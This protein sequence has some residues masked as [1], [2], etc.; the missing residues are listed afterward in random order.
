M[1]VSVKP[2]KKKLFQVAKE[3]NLSTETI[4]EFL[5]KK[6]IAVR[7]HNMRLTEDVYQMVLERFSYEK[8]VAEKIEKRRKER[9]Q[10]EAPAKEAEPVAET[11]PEA[12]VAAPS[13]VE[14]SEEE[15]ETKEEVEHPEEVA[16]E[17]E[18]E[19]AEKVE[20]APEA[21]IE[22]SS[23]VSE[24]GEVATEAIGEE[25]SEE[26]ATPEQE[27]VVAETKTPE[28]EASEGMEQE[29]IPP[30]GYKVGDIVEHPGAKK[31]LERLEE[32]KKRKQERQKQTLERLKKGEE[33][34][35]PKSKK[36]G[37]KRKAEI[38]EPVSG[39]VSQIK[40]EG[41][42]EKGKPTT[43]EIKESEKEKKKKRKKGHREDV[44][45][46]EA[47]RKK[48]YEMVRRESKKFRTQLLQVDE[49]L[50][51]EV[52]KE[53][54]GG[55]RRKKKKVVDEKEVETSLKKTLAEIKD[56]GTGKKKRKKVKDKTGEVVEEERNVIKVTEFIT[57]QDLANLLNVSPTEIIGKCLEL[58][59]MVT[60]N[61]RLDMDTITLL[62]EEYGY[63]V[64]EEEEIGSHFLEMLE[65]EEDAPE[66][67]E[68]RPPVVTVMGHVDH[69][70]TSLLDYI[71]KTNVVAKESGGITQHIG[72]YEVELEDG[73]KITFLD[74]P[75]HEAFTAM[76]AR[77][78]QATD[79]VVL[80]IAADDRVM[81]Q[82][83]EALDHAKA[84][85]VPIIFALNKVDKPNADPDAIRKQLAERNVLVEDW[86]GTYQC[87]EVSAKT[88]QNIHEL[89]EKILLEAELLELKANPN[90]RA[91]GI[92]L[93][94]QL[95][96]GRGPV[97]TVLV[98]DGTLKVGDVFVAG[99]QWGR[100]RAMID[101][102]GQ[103]VESA[104]PSKPVQILGLTGLPE[105]GDKL[106]VLEDEK[107]AR[108]IAY[109]RQQLKREQDFRQVRLTT[110]DELSRQIEA[111][112][113][114]E[115]NIIV[116]ADVD[117]SAQALTDAL[118]RLSTEDVEVQ[119]IRKAVGAISESDVILAAASQAIIIG[120]NVRP[121]LKAKEL[122]E[123]EKVDIRVYKV[124]Y[125]AI[126][127]VKKALEGLL[128]PEVKEVTI[129]TLEVRETFKIS[130]IGTV[131]GCY[132]LSGKIHRNA[133]VRLIRNDVEVYDGKLSSLKRFKDDVR[134]VQAGYECGLTLE[135]F[136]DIKPGDIIEVYEL[137]E[138]ARTLN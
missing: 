50:E 15:V 79:I 18:T 23:A 89:L 32:E 62:A 98:S 42:P 128:E 84:A 101:D 106:I 77:G 35:P 10:E 91:R 5:E 117:G 83:E 115:L 86:G 95:D 25:V 19:V 57:T 54:E 46:R 21:E 113:V 87:V 6:G 47:R 4:K 131:A 125:D 64:E 12:E 39:D 123:K 112:N 1:T 60:I 82:T 28:E 88:G 74:T 58:G 53:K 111:G 93:E 132:V 45:E 2:Q 104:G 30:E 34:K 63:E 65:E 105:A 48:A 99:T 126:E 110:L 92:I 27:N 120:F 69:G 3:L 107:N 29:E 90:K 81:P 136:N 31:Y 129:G 11:Q 55:R 66:D 121:T 24:E 114:K 78:A 26:A 43:E 94:A 16:P 44:E 137:V 22:E 70:K 130:R 56:A 71:R 102:K 8:K 37:G 138:E 108:E 133:N 85:G 33:P 14:V 40:D 116:K 38:E 51:E 109:Q 52:P 118:Y 7:N 41:I 124:I 75:G 135:N 97:A 61:Q 103:R 9:V 68:P 127:D 100:V 13:E 119:V 67:L 49:E 96:K 17:S 122:A 76:R 59:L 72:A 73:R 36:K 80:V 134:E 20:K